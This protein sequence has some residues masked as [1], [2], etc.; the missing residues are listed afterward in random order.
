MAD[1]RARRGLRAGRR[2]SVV[3]ASAL[4]RLPALCAAACRECGG[5]AAGAGVS[6]PLLTGVG[7][8][9]GDPQLVTVKGVRVLQQA[10]VVFVPVADSGEVGRAEATVRAHVEGSRIRRLVFALTEPA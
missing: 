9:P 8:G 4:G 5:P 3:P 2:A 6:A 7:V 1:R 10:D